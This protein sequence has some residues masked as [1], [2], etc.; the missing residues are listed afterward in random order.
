M[1]LALQFVAFGS[2]GFAA[3][4]YLIVMPLPLPIPL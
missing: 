3:L 2:Y 4:Q 1:Y